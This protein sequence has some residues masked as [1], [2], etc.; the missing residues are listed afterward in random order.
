M[1]YAHDHQ[2]ND[3]IID[4]SDGNLDGIELQVFNEYLEFSTPVR[5]FATK[6]KQGRQALRHHYKVQAADDFEEKLAKRIAQ[7]KNKMAEVDF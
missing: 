2:L 7:E 5:S 1:D 4:F 6:A 3:F